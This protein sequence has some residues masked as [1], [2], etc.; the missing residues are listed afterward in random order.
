MLKKNEVRPVKNW[1]VYKQKSKR[2]VQKLKNRGLKALTNVTD[3]GPHILGNTI[4]K[5]HWTTW[6]IWFKMHSPHPFLL[7]SKKFLLD[8]RA[9]DRRARI[10]TNQL[11]L[12]IT[13]KKEFQVWTVTHRSFWKQIRQYSIKI[14][15]NHVVKYIRSSGFKNKSNTE[16]HRGCS[17]H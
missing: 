4:K 5:I 2:T 15:M 9:G 3:A 14:L 8:W 1:L 11:S 12:R 7:F 6:C 17:W 13:S 10:K 16:R